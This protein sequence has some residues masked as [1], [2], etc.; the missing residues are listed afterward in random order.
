MWYIQRVL[1]GDSRMSRKED[2]LRPY[3]IDYF[4]WSEMLKD[5][6]LVRS[7]VVRAVTAEDA[8]VVVGDAVINGG[9]PGD[10]FTVIRAYR[11]YKKLTAEPLRKVYIPIDKL[12]PAKWAITV[13]TEI[14]NR[15]TPPLSNV[16]GEYSA[17]S[18]EV[19]RGMDKKIDPTT[20]LSDHPD[21]VCTDKCYSFQV[22]E[23]SVSEVAEKLRQMASPNKIETAV[24]TAYNKEFGAPC[25]WHGGKYI[26]SETGRCTAIDP[27][28]E[29]LN[30]FFVGQRKPLI[31]ERTAFGGPVD[32][33]AASEEF[34][35]PN[36]PCA[37]VKDATFD[38]AIDPPD[39]AY[40]IEHKDGI[41]ETSSGACEG[42]MPRIEG[43]LPVINLEL[44]A[45][46]VHPPSL[47]SD[48]YFAPVPPQNCGGE[49]YI[50][51]AKLAAT[52]EP[53]VPPARKFQPL[54]PVTKL[55]LEFYQLVL[56]ALAISGAAFVYLHYFAK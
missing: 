43:D 24:A 56:A 39:A 33:Y 2:K 21:H 15:K 26:D 12:L 5:K 19:L 32:H 45:P 13:M 14:E 1:E 20:L 42:W 30:N 53:N 23:G 50:D 29:Y 4:L 55:T 11:F 52:V 10:N 49:G 38:G 17:D 34:V 16:T 25:K 3:R 51:P 8:K 18:I 44:A 54:P 37:P 35:F 47:C 41:N 9:R 22:I 40:T 46:I 48:E 28:S 27:G 6:A 36:K 7:V 31:E